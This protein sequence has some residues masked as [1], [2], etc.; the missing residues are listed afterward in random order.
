MLTTKSSC[1][2]HLTY[3]INTKTSKQVQGHIMNIPTISQSSLP[4]SFLMAATLNFQLAL[5]IHT[6]YD[7]MNIPVKFVSNCQS[8]LGKKD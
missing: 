8:N 1:G 3:L 6:M 4:V 5:T 2:I 7:L